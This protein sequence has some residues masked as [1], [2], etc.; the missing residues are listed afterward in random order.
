MSRKCSISADKKIWKI[1]DAT[2]KRLGMSRSELVQHLIVYAGLVGGEYPL[3]SQILNSP[4]SKRDAFLKET[5][6][7]AENND[8]IKKQAF[9]ATVRECA[10][11]ADK[12]TC[13]KVSGSL[14]EELLGQ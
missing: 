13:D 8:P 11:K 14:L 10:G 6:R 7:R 3:T 1:A 12:H 2:A 5:L 4:Q 9:W